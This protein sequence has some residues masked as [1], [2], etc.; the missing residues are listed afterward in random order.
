MKQIGYVLL[1]LCM[2][3]VGYSDHVFGGELTMRYLGKPGNYRIQLNQ[4]LDGA[5]VN[6]SNR[7]YSV[8]V[9][10]FRKKNPVL[11]DSFI[12]NFRKRETIAYE[13]EACAKSQNLSTFNDTFDTDVQLNVS[14]YADPDG[15]YIVFERCCRDKAITNVAKSTDVGLVFYLEFP[16]LVRN[17]VPFVNSSPAFSTPGGNYLCLNKLFTTSYSATDADG[18]E[19]RYSLVTPYKGYTDSSPTNTNGNGTP[20]LSYP[21]VT[22][23][24]GFGATNAI[25]GSPAL[26]VD[27]NTGQLSVKASMT[28]YFLFTV[29]CDEYRAGQKIGTIRRD[30]LLPVVDCPK[31]TPPPPSITI[32]GKQ[33]T[34]GV[35]CAGASLTLTTGVDP[36]SA[37]QWQRDGVNLPGSTATALAVA[38]PGQYAVVRRFVNICASEIA[39]SPLP[40]QLAPLPSVVVDSIPPI[41]AGGPLVS[42]IGTPATGSWSGKGVTR[43][44]FDPSLTG[45]GLQPV[46]YTV[47]DGNGCQNSVARWVRVTP[48][49]RLEG[50][51]TYQVQRNNSVQL[52]LQPNVDGAAIRWSPASYLSNAE[53]LAPTYQSGE[54]TTYTVQAE[55][56]AGCKATASVAVEVLERLYIPTAFS[57]NGD[58]ENEQWRPINSECFPNC[59]VAVY[60]R[61]GNLVYQGAGTNAIW[62][63]RSGQGVV[64]AG[65]Y[66]YTVKTAPG[67]PVLSG[68]L[69]VLR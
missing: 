69:T 57:P 59:E 58:G 50:A 28:G 19:L 8:T 37:F 23:A 27:A 61:W 34:E 63:G 67:D 39:S 13:N 26:Q 32:N 51:Q 53:V 24:P 6:A 11:M 1:L 62:D 43:A 46:R 21:L 54:S 15:Y 25:P 56:V 65:V 20:R 30:F 31:N 45:E 49:L 42:L 2:P 10:V 35:M 4:F 47:T 52:I 36:Q 40:V 18:D 55:T 33:A 48:P 66:T 29:Q 3:L 14:D 64:E 7:D 12:L 38:S 22:W 17:G 44:Q 68:K 41:C 60:D 9:Y 16:A 5:H